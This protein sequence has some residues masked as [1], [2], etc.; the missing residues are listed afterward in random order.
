MSTAGSERGLS[1]RSPARYTEAAGRLVDLLRRR[2]G[3]TGRRTGRADDVARAYVDAEAYRLH[4]YW[5]AS[6]VVD[7]QA[8]GPE[9]SCNKIFWS[10][11]DLAIHA[12]ALSLLGPEAELLERPDVEGGR[13]G[14][15][16]ARRLPLRP[17]RT[18]LR[19]D[20]RDPAQR[21]GRAPARAA[22]G[23]RPP[24]RALRLHRAAARAARRGASG[25]RARVHGRRPA[26]RRR[27]RPGARRRAPAAERWSVLAEPRGHRPARPRGP[28]GPR[29][30]RG[31]P[32]RG[33]SRRRAGPPCPSRS[34]SRPALAAPLL[35]EIVADAT[36]GAGHRPDRAVAPPVASG[37]GGGDRRRGRR[38]AHRPALGHPHRRPTSRR[39]P[40]DPPGGGRRA[41]RPRPLGPR[42]AG[43]GLAAP[44]GR[45]ATAVDGGHP[46]GG[47][48]PG[49]RHARVVAR[50]RTP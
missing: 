2:R 38:R 18:D 25:P 36:Q 39:A 47:P 11:T 3:R 19:R 31:R 9:A 35:G 46:V 4:T 29:P 17:G 1:L 15:G 12:A 5:T 45:V 6:R 44:P 23:L 14:P 26:R 50:R 49:P 43:V 21:G 22:A 27:V 33:R 30:G 40:A 34:P 16:L 13:P 20:Q 10:E 32:G 24:G 42:P 7:G 48:H 28:R 8:I 41:G 37:A